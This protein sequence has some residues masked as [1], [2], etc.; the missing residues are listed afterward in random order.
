MRLNPA[1]NCDKWQKLVNVNRPKYVRYRLY[2]VAVK[3]REKKQKS[4][5]MQPGG[6]SFIG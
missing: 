4:K 5:L 2:S 3:F 1:V 6:P